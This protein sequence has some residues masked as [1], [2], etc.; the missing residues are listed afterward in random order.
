VIIACVA[1]AAAARRRRLERAGATVL[2]L[3]AG[4]DGRVDLRRLARALAGDGITSVLV[5]GGGEVHAAL[6]A[7]GLADEVVLHVAPRILGGRRGGPAWV[8]GVEVARLADARRL[9]V[10]SVAFA[11]DDLIVSLR[12]S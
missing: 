2:A 10:R 9:T 8:G 4:R 7:A 6:L 5:E 3:P 1:G 12:P 11:R